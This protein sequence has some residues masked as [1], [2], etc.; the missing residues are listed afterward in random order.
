MQSIV[1]DI[2]SSSEDELT[3][4]AHLSPSSTTYRILKP[5]AGDERSGQASP[6][7]TRTA[8]VQ[9][10]PLVEISSDEDSYGETNNGRLATSPII[11]PL[12]PPAFN[13]PDIS[14]EFQSQLFLSD[15]AS[16]FQDASISDCEDTGDEVYD[17][18]ATESSHQTSINATDSVLTPPR[19]M[20][21]S[22]LG[23]CS[24]NKHRTAFSPPGWESPLDT[25]L[26]MKEDDGGNVKDTN[27]LRKKKA[28]LPSQKPVLLEGTELKGTW[29]TN[30]L[31][32]NDYIMLDTLGKGSYGEVRL[33]KE[34]RTNKLFAMKIMSKANSKRVK[35][36]LASNEDVKREVAIMK[37]LSHENV[38][39]LYEVIDDPRSSTL[40]LILEYMVS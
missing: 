9:R 3:A 36:H 20:H 13:S 4:P 39:R 34:R 16:C 1:V 6:S 38:L 17:W 14:N 12:S 31:V 40:Y 29:I 26:A 28:Q 25:K 11:S 33:C 32:V 15:F 5:N 23:T 18:L 10:K 30:R 27:Q 2:S 24:T 21:K 8:R 37:K 7:R 22:A 19:P 35:D